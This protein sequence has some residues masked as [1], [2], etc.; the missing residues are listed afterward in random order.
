MVSISDK[1]PETINPFSERSELWYTAR[2]FC[3]MITAHAR[4]GRFF[5][6]RKAGALLDAG[7]VDELNVLYAP[8]VLGDPA[9]RPGLAITPRP[10]ARALA[11]AP[12]AR[13][14]LGP[15]TLIRLRPI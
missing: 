5:N 8:K 9:A 13:E 10:L 3:G 12:V 2:E 14:A 7:L 1:Y 11:F 4:H 6:E 15:D